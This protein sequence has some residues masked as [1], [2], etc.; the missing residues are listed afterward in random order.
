MGA[1]WPIVRRRRASAASIAVA[2]LASLGCAHGEDRPVA[3]NSLDQHTGDPGSTIP[4][5]RP[6]Y[7]PNTAGNIV[8]VPGNPAGNPAG[9]PPIVGGTLNRSGGWPEGRQLH[10]VQRD[11]D[12]EE[13]EGWR[14]FLRRLF[15]RC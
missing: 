10:P 6:P 12:C 9:A 5:A 3:Q 15:G 14:L 11:P 4:R 1:A 7:Y 2:L 8:A 13:V